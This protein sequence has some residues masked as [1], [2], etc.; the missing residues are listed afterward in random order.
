MKSLFETYKTDIQSTYIISLPNNNISVDLTN[1]CI[2]SLN[3]I[4]QQY[5][6][7]EG[8]DGT[9][10][11]QIIPP[12]N[13][14][15]VINWLKIK[16]NQLSSTQI[17]CFL[18]HFSLWCQCL[19]LNEPISILEHDAIMIKPYKKHLLY[20]S[21]VYL[22]SWEQY[23]GQPIYTTPPHA[24][25]FNGLYRSICRAHAY[26]IDPAIA[27]KLVSYTLENGITNS[28]DLYIRADLFPMVMFDLFAFDAPSISTNYGIED[29]KYE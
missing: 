19:D 13:Y 16:T 7:W 4:N 28:L 2:E 17:S 25:D 8:F 14:N 5:T 21:I 23:N 10:N 9:Q 26:S 3:N 11:N 12:K 20:N 27:R 15:P 6:I 22:G 24:S 18:S 1:R 29:I